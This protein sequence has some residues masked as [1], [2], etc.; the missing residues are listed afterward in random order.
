M[1]QSTSTTPNPSAAKDAA[2]LTA[3]QVLPSCGSAA[4]TITTR[5]SLRRSELS[6]LNSTLRTDRLN[7]ASRDFGN[8]EPQIAF[9]SSVA[10]SRLRRP[11]L[12][13]GTKPK[14]F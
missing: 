8:D 5:E 2:R 11:R 13:L 9:G 10:R 6:N 12:K 4:V 14:H 3:I 1:S 7:I